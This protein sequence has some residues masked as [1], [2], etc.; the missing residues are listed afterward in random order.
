MTTIYT[1]QDRHHLGRFRLDMPVVA[2]ATNLAE[3][4][5]ELQ[6]CLHWQMRLILSILPCLL[7][8]APSRLSVT[9][10]K[11]TSRK[12]HLESG[13][14]MPEVVRA[15][16]LQVLGLSMGPLQLLLLPLFSTLKKCHF[17]ECDPTAAARHFW[18]RGAY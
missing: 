6:E 4:E 17:C 16:S 7:C 1:Q 18:P 9:A 14:S 12:H 8:E 3:I 10:K 15:A 13:L 11:A 2:R 5:L